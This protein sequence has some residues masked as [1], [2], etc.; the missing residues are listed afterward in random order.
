MLLD[1]TGRVALITG[2]SR[3]I[4]L[5]AARKLAEQGAL[6]V[7]VARRVDD[8]VRKQFEGCS[9][10]VMEGDAGDPAFA[11]Q[12]VKEIFSRHRRLDVLVNNA[13]IMRP[14]MI[15]MIAETDFDETFRTNVGSVVHFTQAA[16]RLMGRANGSIINVSSIV[17]ARG[18]AGQL[19]YAASKAAVI[20]ATRAAAKEL[21]QKNIRVNAIA[22]GFIDTQLAQ[23]LGEEVRQETLSRIGMGRSGTVDEVAD[24]ILFLASDLSRYM[25][26]QVLGVDGGM[27][28]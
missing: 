10:L 25:T 2:A 9:S 11:Q 24:V 12:V 18:S 4:G 26:G 13:G 20:G 23:S 27:V 19:V 22:P 6:V 1:L 28:M 15:G 8:E 7:L 3:G 21:A 16:A 17:G 5:A 14:A